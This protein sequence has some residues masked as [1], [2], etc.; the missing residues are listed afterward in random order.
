MQELRSATHREQKRKRETR[1]RRKIARS[2]QQGVGGQ[3]GTESAPEAPERMFALMKEAIFRADEE[4]AASEEVDHLL[5]DGV[6]VKLLDGTEYRGKE[7]ACEA[8][9]LTVKRVLGRMRQAI[10]DPA[11]ARKATKLKRSGP[12]LTSRGSWCLDVSLEFMLFRST[13]REE[14]FLNNDGRIVRLERSAP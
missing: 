11:R 5:A 3:G 1:S 12:F 13:T 6:E 2:L 14:Y 9:N 10:I 8:L 4:W 7:G